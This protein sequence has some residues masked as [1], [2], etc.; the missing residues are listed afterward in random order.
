MVIH[1]GGPPFS[2]ENLDGISRQVYERQQLQQLSTINGNNM[3][4]AVAAGASAVGGGG[5]GGS[6]G[7]QLG[8][9]LI[10][11]IGGII[12]TSINAGAN[13]NI[14]EMGTKVSMAQLALQR[15]MFTRSW[16]AAR[17]AGLWSPDQ[18]A[19]SSGSNYYRGGSFGAI[20]GARVRAPNT[21]VYA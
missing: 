4:E 9:A 10:G 5:G 20:T 13:Q 1:V 15:E 21:S 18:F 14:A 12:S 16:N 17:S 2:F 19:G 8:A 7:G 11:S 6:M 3:E